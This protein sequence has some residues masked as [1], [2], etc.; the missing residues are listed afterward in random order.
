MIGCS[1][2]Q[3][4][5][6]V[7][8][9]LAV[10]DSCFVSRILACSSRTQSVRSSILYEVMSRIMAGTS[11]WHAADTLCLSMYVEM[12]SIRLAEASSDGL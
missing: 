11:D 4:L 1:A 12:D 3:R 2:E 7:F 5:Y 9:N 10:I 8:A 6:I